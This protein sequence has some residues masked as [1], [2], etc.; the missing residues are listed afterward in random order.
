MGRGW[1]GGGDQK[2]IEI[3]GVTPWG[4]TTKSRGTRKYVVWKYHHWFVG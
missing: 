1:I 4:E 2:S 3:I